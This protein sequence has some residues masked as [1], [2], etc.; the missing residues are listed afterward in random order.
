MRQYHLDKMRRL[1]I[2]KYKKY[3][4]QVKYKRCY[5]WPRN[6]NQIWYAHFIGAV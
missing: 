3:L 4:K 6:N 5:S 1:R 2:R